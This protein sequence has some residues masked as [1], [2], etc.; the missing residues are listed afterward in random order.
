MGCYQLQQMRCHMHCTP[1][2]KQLSHHSY[3]RVMI[4]SSKFGN[5]LQVYSVNNRTSDNSQNS[6]IYKQ[7]PLNILSKSEHTHTHTPKHTNTCIVVTGITSIREY[8]T[9]KDHILPVTDLYCSAVVVHLWSCAGLY[10]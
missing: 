2:K 9:F 10:A 6:G 7:T 4:V 8:I 1:P 3:L 5:Y